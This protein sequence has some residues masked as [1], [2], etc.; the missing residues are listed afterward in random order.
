VREETVLPYRETLRT[1]VRRAALHPVYAGSARTGAGVAELVT[2]ITEL[3]PPN[4]GAADGP[5]S[6]T[7]FKV[8]RGPAAERIAYAR[9]F[10]GTL[11]VR[12]RLPAGRI[13]GITVF[14]NGRAVRAAE[15][16]PGRIGQLW[17]LDGVRVGDPIGVAPAGP[18]RQFAPPTLETVVVP[19]RAGELG[20]L[21]TALAQMAEQDPLINLRLDGPNQEIAVSLYGEVQK[22]VI[23][24]TLADEF[25]VDVTFRETT[26]IHIERPVGVG[27]ALAAIKHGGNPFL[28]TVGLRIEP[29]PVDSGV[30]F[31]LGIELG[32]LPPAFIRA[33]EETVHATLRHGGLAGRRVT[34]CVVTMTHSGYWARQSHTHGTFDKS[35]SST[36]GDFRGVTPLVLRRALARAGTTVL[37][38]IHRFHL[39][40][41]AGAVPAV[42][43]V[44]ARLGGV[45]R[46]SVSNGA[47]YVIE[48]DVPAARVRE[49]EQRLPGVTGGEGVLESAFDHYRE[50]C[51]QSTN[52]SPHSPESDGGDPDASQ[53]DISS[54]S[55]ADPIGYPADSAQPFGV[56]RNPLRHRGSRSV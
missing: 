1:L 37:E 27:T 34:D 19:R 10:G 20:A 18:A 3:L 30:T 26:T 13:T 29:G 11:R 46:S 4:L 41:P 14:D 5:V 43:P 54:G 56:V 50:L 52:S 2:G 33:V 24:Q 32:S 23:G 35:M 38:P 44:L 53:C 51:A 28:A 39:D 45:P 9:V 8:V 22:E 21:H 55:D 17:G 31:V 25:G 48:G 36:A 12:D 42:R 7:V 40:I 49:L 15:L 16:G 47:G 6:G